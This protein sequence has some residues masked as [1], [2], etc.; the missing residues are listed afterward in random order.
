[1]SG[2]TSNNSVCLLIKKRAEFDNS[3]RNRFK[4]SQREN[5][6]V[7]KLRGDENRMVFAFGDL[8]GTLGFNAE[9]TG[10]SEGQFFILRIDHRQRPLA[11]VPR[12][13]AP[14]RGHTAPQCAALH[15]LRR[16]E[17]VI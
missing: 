5:R 17:E 1:M 8:A 2:K 10:M 11:A 15:D 6:P 13:V 16:L 3:A 14:F 7:E 12:V 4:G 9:V